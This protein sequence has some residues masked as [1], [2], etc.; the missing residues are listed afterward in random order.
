MNDILQS[1]S[2][3]EIAVGIW[4]MAAIAYI[5]A[6]PQTR[7]SLARLTREF[8][9]P[10]FLVPLGIAAI[11]ALGEVYLLRQ[12]GW[13]SLANLKTTILWIITF[14]FVSMFEVATAGKRKANFKRVA[15]EILSVT[16]VLTFVAELHSFSLATELVAIPIVTLLGLMTAIADHDA[17][18][19]PVA[20]ILTTLSAI[21]GFGYLGFSVWMSIAEWQKTASSDTALEFLIPL[22]LSVGFLPFLYAWLIYVA[23]NHTF[24]TLGVF[25]LDKSLVPRARW[26]AATRIRDDTDLLERWHRAIQQSRPSTR[27][28]L[29]HSLSAL[30]ALKER[31]HS[32]PVVPPQEGWSPYLAMQFLTDLG[33]DTGHYKNLDGEWFASTPIKQFGTD[34]PMP[35][36]LAYYI[37]GH[38]HAAT[39]LK[40]K[41][42]INAPDAATEAEDWFIVCAMHLLE[43][44]V[45]LDAVERMKLDIARFND[46]IWA[47]P[48]GEVSLRREN[49]ITF[50]E[51]SYSRYFEI[52]RGPDASG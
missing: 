49:D 26:L 37:E 39:T 47:I 3:R 1:F 9:K 23:Y 2:H 8:F 40:L 12:I 42:N 14:A 20:K 7:T 35:N 24:T 45:S 22:I 36:N 28:E 32:P 10:I 44:A 33:F 29:D 51:G 15:G 4:L 25:G 11:Y 6:R 38:E 34:L 27:E 5:I 19:A 16:G 41:L 46:F 31:E 30:L 18:H 21:I 52:R 48:Y 13:W 43:H 50:V 17:K